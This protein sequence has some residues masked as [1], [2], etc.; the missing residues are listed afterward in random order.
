M[1]NYTL[2]SF[3]NFCD[4]MMI[5]EEGLISKIKEKL[6]TRGTSKKTSSKAT[7][8]PENVT[9]TLKKASSSDFEHLYK[10]EAYCA[11][12]LEKP[13]SDSTAEVFVNAFSK[14]NGVAS[15]INFYYCLGKDLNK[16]YHLT[17]DN[18]YPNNLGIFFIDWSNFSKDFA[19]S[20]HKGKFRY[21]SDVVDNNARREIRKNNPHYKNY[22]SLYGDE[23]FYSTI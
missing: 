15:H 13:N 6:K 1:N 17:G 14:Y 23:W 7:N 19:A 9:Y 2:E 5:A 16:Y 11:E 3:I 10:T 8:I 22:H 18:T 12:G 4:D 20:E 21:F